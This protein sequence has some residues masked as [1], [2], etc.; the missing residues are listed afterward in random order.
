MGELAGRENY[1]TVVYILMIPWYNRFKQGVNAMSEENK[2]ILDE[3][4]FS[5]AVEGF[6]VTDDEKYK[7]AEMLEGKRT[8]ES[9]VAECVSEARAYAGV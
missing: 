9:I 7:V 5:L 1:F 2:K 3:A 8:L 4:A 6:F